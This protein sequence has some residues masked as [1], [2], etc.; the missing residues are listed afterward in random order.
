[1]KRTHWLTCS[2]TA[3]A[4][5]I[6][7]I[8]PLTNAFSQEITFASN[9]SSNDALAAMQQA[10]GSGK[11]LFVYFWKQNDE[12]NRSMRGVFDRTTSRISDR[13]NTTVVNIADPQNQP[14]VNKFGV[15]RAPMPLVLAI[16]PNGAVT[17]GLPMAFDEKQLL[18]G[19]VSDATATC[20]KA[21]QDRKVVLLCVKQSFDST[22]FQGVNDFA[23]D[24]RFVDACQIVKLDPTDVSEG[25]FLA[26]LKVP[27]STR[28]GVMVVLAPP[29][30]P[31]ATFAA[32]ATKDQIIAKLEAASSTCCPGGQ[33]VPSA[34]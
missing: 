8:T 11:Y 4:M 13:V 2:A 16:A 22:S 17:K 21:L 6:L 30:Q 34:K 1:M 20:L 19:L 23:N 27:A 31:I 12:Q 32:T 24:P 14:M 33:C 5:T 29:G 28:E 25:K 9:S 3:V 7:A 10:A 15:S 26:S 18:E